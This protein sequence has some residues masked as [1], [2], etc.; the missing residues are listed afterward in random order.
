MHKT[1]TGKIMLMVVNWDS[2]S[3]RIELGFACINDD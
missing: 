3:K 2:K 1:H